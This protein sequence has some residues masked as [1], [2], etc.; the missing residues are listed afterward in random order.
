M[1]HANSH[2]YPEHRWL[3][4]WEGRGGRGGREGETVHQPVTIFTCRGHLI[5]SQAVNEHMIRGLP[6]VGVSSLGANLYHP[7]L[8][9]SPTHSSFIPVSGTVLSCQSRLISVGQL[10]YSV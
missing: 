1:R 9:I 8:I 6:L 3:C 4:H 2:T 5:Y 10:G 7:F